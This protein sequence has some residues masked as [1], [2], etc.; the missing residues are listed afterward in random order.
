MSRYIGSLFLAVLLA[1]PFTGSQQ[2]FEGHISEL[3]YR[4]G[5]PWYG[6]HVYAITSI[7]DQIYAK[8]AFETTGG[9]RDPDLEGW[10]VQVT[11]TEDESAAFDELCLKTLRLPDWE[12]RYEDNSIT[13]QDIWSLTYTLDGVEYETSGYAL[14]PKDLSKIKAFFDDLDWPED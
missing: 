3:R 11:L 6:Y 7:D 13:C 10:E 8:K 4:E 12:E 9:M 1:L 2:S 14:F 5:H